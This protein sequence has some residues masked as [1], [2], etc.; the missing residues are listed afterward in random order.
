MATAVMR[1]HLLRMIYDR[2][3]IVRLDEVYS[4]SDDVSEEELQSAIADG[5]LDRH[6]AGHAEL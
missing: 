5:E 2:P 3:R 1:H 4:F 6:V